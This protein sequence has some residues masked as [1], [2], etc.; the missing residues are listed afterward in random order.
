MT[1][2]SETRALLA[3]PRVLKVGP[4]RAAYGKLLPPEVAR[5]IHHHMLFANPPNHTRLRK[6]LTLAFARSRVERLSPGI[7]LITNR[8]LNTLDPSIVVDLISRFAFPLPIEVI[9]TMV[10]VPET[11]R[12]AFQRWSAP[13]SAPESVF[14][15]GVSSVRDRFRRALP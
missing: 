8:L 14:V 6:L 10:G 1:G 15:R 9:S 4:E 5:G 13:L 7:R 12:D 3:D 11:A 2:H